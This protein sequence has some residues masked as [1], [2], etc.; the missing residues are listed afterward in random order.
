MKLRIT[1]ASN[2]LVEDY[3]YILTNYILVKYKH[4]I[5]KTDILKTDYEHDQYYASLDVTFVEQFQ[6]RTTV[7]VIGHIA[8]CIVD[9]I[10]PCV[11]YNRDDGY[12][13]VIYDYYIE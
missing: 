8:M 10:C 1:A 9:L 5:E 4:I 6:P 11:I 2:R 12:E 7:A 13:I 3:E